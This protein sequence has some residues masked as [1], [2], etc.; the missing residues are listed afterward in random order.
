MAR[1]EQKSLDV[2]G[3]HGELSSLAMSHDGGAREG[4]SMRGGGCM[5]GCKL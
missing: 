4:E 5:R 1:S 2:D 3:C